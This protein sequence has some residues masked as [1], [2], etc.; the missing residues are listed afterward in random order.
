[1]YAWVKADLDH[2]VR[3]VGVRSIV[4][5]RYQARLDAK[6]EELARVYCSVEFIHDVYSS[7]AQDPEFVDMLQSVWLIELSERVVR[8]YRTYV[9]YRQPL[10]HTESSYYVPSTEEV[11]AGI[12][13]Y[14]DPAHLSVDAPAAAGQ[15][16]LRENKDEI[17][18]M[19]LVSR[20][21]QVHLKEDDNPQGLLFQSIKSYIAVLVWPGS[22]WSYV[23]LFARG[24]DFTIPSEVSDAVSTASSAH[25]LTNLLQT[26]EDASR[27]GQYLPAWISLHTCLENP[28]AG[29]ACE[30]PCVYFFVKYCFEQGMGVPKLVLALC[31]RMNMQLSREFIRCANPTCE[32][33]RLDKST[34][35]V[36]FK[37]CS[38]CMSAI[39]CSRECQTAHYP[40][41]KR[42]CRAH[43]GT[44]R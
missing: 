41:H 14:F 5:T 33:N 29:P 36:K 34:G 37:K 2:Y 39:Y 9:M 42:L 25:D 12:K 17:I 24:R 1:M 15:E 13:A 21:G 11:I 7:L 38:R 43:S 3:K 18:K 32:L 44:C 26:F 31:D 19:C 8:I 23:D 4:D 10:V 22:S 40:E 30:R 35:Q 28:D 6:V 16:S 27:I 20:V